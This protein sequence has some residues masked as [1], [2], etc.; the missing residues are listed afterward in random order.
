MQKSRFV[1][2][3]TTFGLRMQEGTVVEKKTIL[4]FT[5]IALNAL[6]ISNMTYASCLDIDNVA[7]SKEAIKVCTEDIK[8]RNGH[9]QLLYHWR[10][11]A[12][13]YTHDYKM[14]I[15]DFTSAIE[16]DPQWEA[17]YFARSDAYLSFGDKQKA[18]ED[19]LIAN[20]ISRQKESP[21]VEQVNKDGFNV[22]EYL[23]SRKKEASR[24]EQVNSDAASNEIVYLECT[25]DFLKGNARVPP[26]KLS[27]KINY[28]DKTVNNKP[29][30]IDS[31]L[32]TFTLGNDT[33]SKVAFFLNRYTGDLSVVGRGKVGQCM[34]VSER[35]F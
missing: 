27:L 26:V 24:V 10:G 21:K 18:E 20:S 3:T 23:D 15:R 32:I 5:I 19:R 14:A 22:I 31:S 2:H 16:I 11:M 25:A 29:A 17:L 33:D 4:A 34:Q 30:L 35:K 9:L 1:E 12:Y 8:A 13:V 6:I 28:S 7:K